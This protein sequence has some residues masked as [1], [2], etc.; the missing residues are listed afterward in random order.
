MSEQTEPKG[1]FPAAARAGFDETANGLPPASS[2]PRRDE[3][4]LDVVPAARAA[5]PEPNPVQLGRYRIVRSLGRGAFGE[6]FLAHDEELDRQV[7]IKTPHPTRSVSA[8]HVAQFLAEA[9]ILAKLDHAAIV[10]VYDVGVAG[11]GRCYVVSK[12]IDGSNLADRLARARPSMAEAVEWVAAIAEALDH[13]HQHRLVHRDVKPRNILLDGAG[14]PF[15]ADFGVALREEDFGRGSRYVGTAHYMSPEQARGEGHLVDGRSDLFSLGV[16]LYELL[17]GQRPFRGRDCHEIL[18]QIR[19]QEV[20]PPRQ[21][22]DQVPKELER[23]CLQALAKRA[24]ER[25]SAALEMAAD[26]RQ[27]LRDFSGA[28]QAGHRDG[29]AAEGDSLTSLDA[30]VPRG[31]RSFEAEDT[32]FFLKLLPGPYDRHGLPR[33]VRFWKTRIESR[34]L[35]RSFRVGLIYG[36]SGSGKS[37]LVKAGL[38]PRLEPRI[39]PLLVEATPADTEAALRG[40]VRDGCGEGTGNADLI[41]MLSEIRRGRSL[42][43]GGKLLLVIDQFEQWLH[44]HGGETGTELC[45]ALRQC[46]GL[47]VQCLLLIRDDFWMSAARFMQE[48]EVRIVEGENSMAVDLFDPRHAR[49]VLA[50]FGRAYEALPRRAADTT[51]EQQQ[52]LD[53]AILGLDQGGKVVAVQLVLFAEMVKSRPWTSAALRQVGGVQGLGVTFLEETFSAP[54]AN[55]ACRLHQAA[56]RGVLRA[57][58]P[59]EGTDIKGRRLSYSELLAASRCSSPADFDELLSVLDADL[60]LLTPV[61]APTAGQDSAVRASLPVVSQERQSDAEPTPAAG[62]FYQLTHDYL[63]PALRQWLTKKQRETRRGRAELRLAERAELWSGRPEAKQ[64]PSFP[65]WMECRVLTRSEDWTEPQRRMMQAARRHHLRRAAA[66]TVLLLV[67]LLGS[68]A[69][70]RDLQARQ[71]VARLLEAQTS[72][73][74]AIVAQTAPLASWVERNLERAD[75][76]QD[77]RKQLH[78]SLARLPRHPVEAAY[79]QRRLLDAPPAEVTV[80]REALGPG[81]ASSIAQWWRVLEDPDQPAGRRFRAACALASLSPSDARWRARAADVAAW[82]TAENPVLA[83]QWSELLRPVKGLLLAPLGELFG[84]Q[85][86]EVRLTASIVLADYLRDDVARLVRLNGDSDEAQ[87]RV[88]SDA[89]RLHRQRAIELLSKELVRPGAPVATDDQ[90]EALVSEK[91]RAAT[92][93]VLLGTAE[94]VWPRLDQIQD[95]LLR[96]SLIHVL[97]HAGVP[98]DLMLD[99]LFAAPSPTLRIALLLSL[100]SYEAAALRQR[101]RQRLMPELRRAYRADPHSGVHAAC[102]WLLRKLA[103]EQPLAAEEDPLR[104]QGPAPDRNW[105]LTSRGQ[106][107]TIIRGPVSFDMGSPEGEIGRMGGESLRRQSIPYTY[108]IASK[109]TTLAQFLEFWPDF[110]GGK[111]DESQRACPVGLVDFVTVS[112]YCNWLSAVEGIPQD[113]WCYEH[114]AQEKL[115]PR[116]DCLTRTGYRLPTEAEWEYACRA[117]TTTPRHDGWGNRFLCEHAWYGENSGDRLHPVGLLKPNDLGLFDIYGNAS[118]WC[119]DCFDAKV[120]NHVDTPLA[121]QFMAIRGGSFAGKIHDLRSARRVGSHFSTALPAL[122]FRVARTLTSANG[123][124]LAHRFP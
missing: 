88:L 102:E 30:I 60:R 96:T 115:R 33:S 62:R 1:K 76:G 77:P 95:P 84:S 53:Q 98:P 26:L 117:G 65:E 37:S 91:T 39:R 50:A 75:P 74:P 35:P 116:K 42:P 38:L 68:F 20:C 97:P 48:Q 99:Q 41:G 32:E 22:N 25:Y 108:A 105:Y 67:A 8:H 56:A 113:Q 2:T 36:P 40:A 5:E 122:G 18:E 4:T 23:I 89:L 59:D 47:R 54:T 31:L 45:L 14:R 80:I 90:R 15:L 92:M 109:E 82:L 103:A 66:A 71:L 83:E 124:A 34:E 17:T 43:A 87:Q 123:E 21:L 13:A 9:R 101:H 51:D 63:V 11:E 6:V 121:E 79:L 7:A 28:G 69:A 3:A 78:V 111:Q 55:P 44:A 85:R 29:S 93:L 72:E 49:R 110:R 114:D 46:D 61:E 10:P 12:Y 57:L 119:Q 107:M 104:G 73:V 118:E 64:L 81:A 70:Y 58:L 112:A 27:F 94:P 52:F 86:P 100:G 16:V 120:Q 19:T 24:S 106:T